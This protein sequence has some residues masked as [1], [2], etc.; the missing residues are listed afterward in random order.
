MSRDCLPL[1]RQKVISSLFFFLICRPAVAWAEGPARS[2][3][4]LADQALAIPPL[5]LAPPHFARIEPDQ[6]KGGD[7]SDYLDQIMK[8]MQKQT[9]G[10]VFRFKEMPVKIYIQPIEPDL[11]QAC[12]SACQLWQSRSNGLARFMLVGDPSQARVQVEWVHLGI[13]PQPGSSSGAHTLIKWQAKTAAKLAALPLVGLPVPTVGKNLTVPPQVIQI[14]LDPLAERVP[15]QQPILLR[16]I[17]MHELGHALGLIGHSPL[18]SDLMYKDTDEY[19]RLSQ[20][21]LNTLKRFYGLDLNSLRRK[22]G[23]KADIPL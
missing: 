14:N 23:I 20:R 6:D 4:G 1:L 2:A 17:L 19:S 8:D 9:Q 10:R 22:Y 11:M 5:D 18:R 15:E 7:R 12:L 13:N 3:V 21:D 16:N